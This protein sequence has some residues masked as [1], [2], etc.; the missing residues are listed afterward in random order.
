MG[1]EFIEFGS[2]W[3]VYIYLLRDV[4]FFVKFVKIFIEEEKIILE[5]DLLIRECLKF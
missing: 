1:K 2:F 5:F 3:N 4:G